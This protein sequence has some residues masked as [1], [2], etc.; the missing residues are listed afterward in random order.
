MKN[1]ICSL[2][3]KKINDWQH[4]PLMTPTVS[5]QWFAWATK[6]TILTLWFYNIVFPC[7]FFLI[8]LF[9]LSERAENI[10]Y[11]VLAQMK[12]AKKP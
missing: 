9:L 8:N 6:V 12:L 3:T 2:Q 11:S 4:L 10:V 7:L 1:P 5:S